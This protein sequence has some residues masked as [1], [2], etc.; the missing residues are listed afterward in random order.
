MVAAPCYAGHRF[1][2]ADPTTHACRSTAR[3]NCA[4][5]APRIWPRRCQSAAVGR[6]PGGA[7]G[8]RAAA[9]I[10][11]RGVWTNCPRNRSSVSASPT[12]SW[13]NSPS[14]GTTR[15]WQ[16]SPCTGHDA[17]VQSRLT[18]D[19][20][21]PCRSF[22][23]TGPLGAPPLPRSTLQLPPTLRCCFLP[24]A[25]R[26]VHAARMRACLLTSRRERNP[27]RRHRAVMAGAGSIS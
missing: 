19:Q 16:S 18:A 25:P 8:C 6:R 22:L 3:A 7:Q 20:R 14:R 9:A 26:R 2:S 17:G 21:P 5:V 24:L 23:E 1:S 27:T 13:A 11:A 15:P 12:R 4:R 10:A